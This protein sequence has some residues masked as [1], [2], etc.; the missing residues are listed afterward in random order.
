MSTLKTIPWTK[1]LAKKLSAVTV[2]NSDDVFLWKASVLFILTLMAL[3]VFYFVRLSY[4]KTNALLDQTSD[5]VVNK[6]GFSIENIDMD[7]FEKAAVLID[8]KRNPLTLPSKIRNVF[9]YNA[10]ETTSYKPPEVVVPV[11]ATSTLKTTSTVK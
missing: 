1:K 11:I 5:T 7:A 2:A 4:Q 10:L 8:Y 9:F 6:S 3:S